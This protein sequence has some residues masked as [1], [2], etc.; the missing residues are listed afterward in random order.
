MKVPRLLTTAGLALALAISGVLAGCG[1]STSSTS[2][3]STPATVAKAVENF[4]TTDALATDQQNVLVVD[5]R[6][7]SAYSTGHIPGAIRNTVSLYS[8]TA[9]ATGSAG[10]LGLTQAEF[11][12]LADKLGITP[13]TKVVAYDTDNSS[14]VGRFVWTLLRYGHKNVA[15]LD[16][17]YQ[18]WIAEGRAKATKANST[19]PTANT[20][21]YTVTSTADID[22]SASYVLSH[23]NVPGT[24]IWDARTPLEYIGYDLRTNPRG[25]TSP[26][27]STSTGRI[28]SIRTAPGP[29]C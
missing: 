4:T 29:M 15:I 28:S 18:K 1:S 22:V 5:V 3:S 20:I 23:I 9:S 8:T 14:S 24:V 27:R 6:A 19:T 2:T 11:V 21:S 12:A 13:S 25:D 16:G 26:M 17:G 7:F 10:T